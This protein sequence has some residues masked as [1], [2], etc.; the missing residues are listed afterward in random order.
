MDNWQPDVDVVH[1]SILSALTTTTP[2]NV[3]AISHSYG[4]LVTN[5]ALGA[6]PVTYRSRLKHIILCGFLLPQGLS[7]RGNNPDAPYPALWAVRDDIVYTNDPAGHFYHD[8]S[9]QD[10]EKFAGQLEGRYMPLA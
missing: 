2:T 3:V 6:I 7:L 5:E 10:Q 4:S 1:T 8:L 9:A